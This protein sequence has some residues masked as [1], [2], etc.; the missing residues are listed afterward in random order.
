MSQPPAEPEFTESQLRAYSGERG[1]RM[2]VGFRGVVYDVTDCPKWRRGLHE[3]LHW[4]GQDLTDELKAAPH[5][6]SVFEHPCARRVG[7]LRP[8]P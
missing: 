8:A 7:I 5:S 6:A 2:Y 3:N 1:Y 4:P